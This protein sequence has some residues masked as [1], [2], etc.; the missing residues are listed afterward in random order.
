MENSMEV[1]QKTKNELPYDP[2]ILLPGFYWRKMKMPIQ[3]VTYTPMF[4]AATINHLARKIKKAK[5]WEQLK[6]PSTDD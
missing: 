6:C 4:I 2:A 3:E 1:P 5:T